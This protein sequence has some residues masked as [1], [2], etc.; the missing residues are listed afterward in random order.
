MVVGGR[1]W[2]VAVG[3]GGLICSYEIFVFERFL[4]L[5]WFDR[6]FNLSLRDLQLLTCANG[7]T[8]NWP[9]VQL[10]TCATGNTCN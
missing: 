3:G 5:F 9:H 2:Q 8:C 4:E 6:F 7:N 10:A 1:W